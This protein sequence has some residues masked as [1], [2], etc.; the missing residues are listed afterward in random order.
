MKTFATCLFAMLISGLVACGNLRASTITLADIPSGDTDTIS[1]Q[2][3]PLD[4]ALDGVAGASLG[5]GFTVNWTSTQGDWASFTSTSLGSVAQGETN[6]G[7]LGSYT[8]FIGAQGGPVDFGLS[9]GTWV[10]AFDGVSQG[11]GVYQITTDPSIAAPGAQDTGQITFNFQVYNG[12]PLSAAQIGD[13][14]Y[15]Y[16]GSSTA[17]SVTVD[18]AA[19]PEPATFSLLLAVAGILAAAY[20]RPILAGVVAILRSSPATGR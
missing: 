8:D 16:Y 19:T 7:L 1:I 10:E 13:A 6:P 17:F 5:W 20:W 18:A 4:G 12:D 9:P 2:L 11:I 14:S 3:M 15:S